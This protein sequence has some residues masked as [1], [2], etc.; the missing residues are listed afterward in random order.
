MPHARFVQFAQS[1]LIRV[2]HQEP[3]DPNACLDVLCDI[4]VHQ[5]EGS[6]LGRSLALREYTLEEWFCGQPATSSE[7]FSFAENTC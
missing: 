4:I 3:R 7:E 5:Q 2:K 6:S 1:I